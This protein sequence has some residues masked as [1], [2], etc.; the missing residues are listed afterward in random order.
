MK[1]SLFTL[2]LTLL[3]LF[4]LCSCGGK[5]DTTTTT[6]P[7]RTTVPTTTSSVAQTTPAVTAPTD[8][9]FTTPSTTPSAPQ[10]TTPHVTTPPVTT[11]TPPV[12]TEP[13]V[14]IPVT[15]YKTRLSQTDDN[16]HMAMENGGVF[17]SVLTDQTIQSMLTFYFYDY[18]KADEGFDTCL[19]VLKSYDAEFFET[20]LL[21]YVRVTRGGYELPEVTEVKYCVAP[22]VSDKDSYHL[23]YTVEFA[24][25]LQKTDCDRDFWVFIEV[26]RP[27]LTEYGLTYEDIGLFCSTWDYP[28]SKPFAYCK[29]HCIETPTQKPINGPYEYRITTYEELQALLEKTE[30]DGIFGSELTQALTEYDRDFF[31]TKFLLVIATEGQDGLEHESVSADFSRNGYELAVF[32]PIR[33]YGNT[34]I[35]CYHLIC[36][37]AK[38]SF[39]VAPQTQVDYLIP[40]DGS[41]DE[42]TDYP[43][44]KPAV[45][46][47]KAYLEKN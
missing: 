45:D 2:G 13:V 29:E 23:E 19:D 6:E 5:G 42:L 25:P 27:D 47:W 8:M 37:L 7:D 3:S 24:E 22:P 40:T 39:G 4:L 36:E 41:F 21:L 32:L 18:D 1:K 46:R 26:D 16:T 10:T 20:K 38:D 28:V 12:T 43:Y 44:A 33:D 30:K 35:K 17:D 11:T 31:V 15:E 34:D 14:Y 9:T